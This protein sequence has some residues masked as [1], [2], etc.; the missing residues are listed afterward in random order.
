MHQPT[1]ISYLSNNS[2]SS[3]FSQSQ[4][5]KVLAALETS[6]A[7]LKGSGILPCLIKLFNM[8]R[9]LTELIPQLRM[10]AAIPVFRVMRSLFPNFLYA[11]TRRIASDLANLSKNLSSMPC[12]S[13]YV[14]PITGIPVVSSISS[15]APT[16]YIIIIKTILNIKIKQRRCK[17]FKN[18]FLIFKYI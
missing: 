14:T 9:L 16:F 5:G 11:S 10:Q 17:L 15:P 18:Y 12:E 13:L 6:L 4:E 3:Q 2:V 1:S 8:R 7:I